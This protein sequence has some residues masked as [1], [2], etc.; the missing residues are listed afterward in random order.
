[1]TRGTV[2][3]R[4]LTCLTFISVREVARCSGG[5]RLPS[6]VL[7]VGLFSGVLTCPSFGGSGVVAAAAAG[8]PLSRGFRKSRVDSPCERS[9]GRR[10]AGRSPNAD[11]RTL[12]FPREAPGR[13]TCPEE[14]GSL[15][16]LEM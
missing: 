6:H 8:R 4:R 11:S 12:R 14:L 13:Q 15:S 16:L 2:A 9:G 10:A 5:R 1:M 3:H 7:C